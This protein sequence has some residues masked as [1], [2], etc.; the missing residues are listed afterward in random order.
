MH[1]SGASLRS[2]HDIP[3]KKE[4]HVITVQPHKVVY[5]ASEYKRKLTA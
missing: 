2:L 5:A 3:A 4:V 1:A